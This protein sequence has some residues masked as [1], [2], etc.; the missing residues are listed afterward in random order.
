MTSYADY[1]AQIAALQ[2]EADAARQNEIANAKAQIKSI[3]DEYGLTIAD[4]S[5]G[6]KSG[7]AAAR[8]PGAP[9]FRGPSERR[10]MV[11]P[12]PGTSLVGR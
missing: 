8:V 12:R 6:A 11:W 7:V 3:M 4:L 1:K 2:K 5:K 10:R 9:Q